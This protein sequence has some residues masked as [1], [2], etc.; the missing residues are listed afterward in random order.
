MPT[1]TSQEPGTQ[2]A[3]PPGKRRGWR[4]PALVVAATTVVVAV[5]AYL[6][7]GF[8]GGS[9]S[10]RP[11]SPK[12]L[13]PSSA[14]AAFVGH[15]VRPDGRVVRIDQ[16]GDTVS[17]GQAY[18]MLMTADTA[19]RADFARVWSW[20]KTHLLEPDGLLAW[21]WK[22]GA[23][24]SREPASDADLGTA[25]AL[26]TAGAKFADPT[27]TAAGRAMA[28]AIARLELAG[29]QYG[30]TLVAGPWA[31]APTEYVDPSYLAPAEIAV[32]ARSLGSPWSAVESASEAE[33][34]AL[35]ANGDLPSNW[36]VVVGG[37]IHPSSP[38]GTT[39]QPAMFGFDAV[40]APLW[41]AT[42]CSARL[43]QSAAGLLPALERG[44]GKVNLTLGGNATPGTTSPI[45][46]LAEAAGDWAAG[47]RSGAWALV[48]QADQA[49]NAHPT[50][51]SSAWLTL[52]VLGFDGDLQS[53]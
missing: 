30:P 4:A 3:G 14:V 8:S 20:T 19:D 18:A 25:A 46:L 37:Q 12:D 28:S 1:A 15:Y 51:Y 49:N 35:T 5:I 21:D 23:V 39:G 44:D 41:M 22:A 10:G 38:P 50:Y 29:S 45:G 9:R 36:A 27:Y 13:S 47:N 52:T 53:C 11:L 16:G 48:G 17:E 34:E 6:A 31:V 40:R 26:L 43:R 32:L 42:S 33:L 24:I 7:V 2:V